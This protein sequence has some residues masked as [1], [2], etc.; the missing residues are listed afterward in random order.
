MRIGN[1]IKY[2]QNDIMKPNIQRAAVGGGSGGG[3]SSQSALAN[4]S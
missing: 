3:Q 1:D 4:L 2:Y